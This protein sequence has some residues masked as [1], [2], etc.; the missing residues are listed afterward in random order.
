MASLRFNEAVF[1]ANVI[2]KGEILSDVFTMPRNEARFLE[3]K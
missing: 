3:R 2:R 1:D